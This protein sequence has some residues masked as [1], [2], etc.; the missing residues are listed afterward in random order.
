MT[1]C[2]SVFSTLPVSISLTRKVMIACNVMSWVESLHED[3]IEYTS[4]LY[5]LGFQKLSCTITTFD[6]PL[7]RRHLMERHCLTSNPHLA[8]HSLYA[9]RGG[10]LYNL[11]APLEYPSALKKLFPSWCPDFHSLAQLILFSSRCL[12]AV[13]LSSYPLHSERIVLPD[14]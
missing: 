11:V 7:S 13:N 6:I 3:K 12:P 9:T 10:P 4:V 14:G 2:N 1:F 8:R 5:F